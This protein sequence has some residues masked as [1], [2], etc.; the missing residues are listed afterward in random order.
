MNPRR[1]IPSK[2]VELA[3][4]VK[5]AVRQRQAM[6]PWLED[7]EFVAAGGAIFYVVDT[8]VIKL[9]TAPDETAVRNERGREGYAQIFP[10]DDPNLSIALGRALADHIF[11]ELTSDQPLLLFPPMEQELR[12][13][14]A[15]VTRDAR[16]EEVRARRELSDLRNKG[17]QWVREIGEIE[18]E[19]A[20]LERLEQDAPTLARLL[21][22]GSGAGA[23]LRRFGELIRSE[24]IAPLEFALEY[25]R[26][27]KPMRDVLDAPR[28][29]RSMLAMHDLRVQW[30]E[31]L[32]ESKSRSTSSILVN[33][34][35]QVLARLEWVNDKLD[36]K[37]YRV[38]FVTGDPSLHVAASRYNVSEHNSS[39]AD[40]FI[41]HPRAYLAEPGVLA[42]DE[43]I[44]KTDGTD[45]PELLNWLD[46]F[47]AK[48]QAED[49]RTRNE[50]YT[51]TL[52]EA[53]DQDLEHLAEKVLSSHP[54]IVDEFREKWRGYTGGLVLAQ[55][56]RSDFRLAMDVDGQ[57][58][59]DALL[60]PLADRLV[61]RVEENWEAFFD[62]A[63]EVSYGLWSD[64]TNDPSRSAP[65]LSFDSFSKAWTFVKN[66]LVSRTAGRVDSVSF[67]RDLQALQEE[68]PSRYTYNLA[69]ALLFAV[70]GFWHVAAILS[71]RAVEIADRERPPRISGREAAYLSA[72]A[73]RHSARRSEDLEN[74]RNLLD[75][76]ERCLR[77]DRGVRPSLRA[78]DLRFPAER[79]ALDLT[80]H[81]FK[82]FLGHTIPDSVRTLPRLQEDLEQQAICARDHLEHLRGKLESS[83]AGVGDGTDDAEHRNF[84]AMQREE[85]IVYSVERN[86]LTNLF[87][88]VLLRA[89]SSTETLGPDELR[90]WFERFTANLYASKSR[91]LPVSFLVRA[92][93]LTADWWTTP[94]KDASL[95]DRARKRLLG[96]LDSDNSKGSAVLP[97]DRK[98][99]AFLRRF[100]TGTG[101]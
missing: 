2:A 38:V 48:H 92:V 52:A 8:D 15:A 22:G 60:K 79:L 94:E 63:T 68:D 12:S 25:D 77:Q 3:A 100:V 27:A 91:R 41:R 55:G 93:Y 86:L 70:E 28:D 44:D 10:D 24:R 20:R 6:Q 29:F 51:E 53:D 97:Y 50:V 19:D 85:W 5:A 89:N 21:G 7:R 49:A 30:F 46:T 71:E 32:H 64:P 13:V 31:W 78:G 45:Y 33:D 73:L 14:V 1:S 9:F 11:T 87:M 42:L 80:Y 18:D 69:F 65:P 57:E 72:V 56:A 83:G 99:F 82:Q 36:S 23:E 39:F 35:A 54:G 76:A 16:E 34:D 81:L 74:I 84:E 26:I 88:T 4:L 62:T 61:Q 37:S 17:R 66:V 90:P 59:I 98:R 95:R 96:H 58:A 101:R 47:L 40:L 75:N 67:R 43:Q